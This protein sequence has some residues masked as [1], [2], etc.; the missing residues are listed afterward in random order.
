MLRFGI[1]FLCYNLKGNVF[2]GYSVFHVYVSHLIIRSLLLLAS[3]DTTVRENQKLKCR[4]YLSDYNQQ[5]QICA[6]STVLA[7]NQINSIVEYYLYN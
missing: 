2:V 5:D 4:P 6:F 3:L 1:K 7:I